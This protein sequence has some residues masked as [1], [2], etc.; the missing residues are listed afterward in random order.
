MDE[1]H[2]S[3]ITTLYADNVCLHSDGTPNEPKYTQLSRLQYF[4]ADH[5]DI[6]LKQDAHRTP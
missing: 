6:L 5:A 1:R 2:G 4:I 3:S